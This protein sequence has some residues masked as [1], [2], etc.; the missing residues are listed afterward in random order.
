MGLG[1]AVV[2]NNILNNKGKI[3]W[4]FRE[5][6]TN[7]LDNGWRFL[8]E[9]DTD[10]FLS[11]SSNMSVCDWG[12]IIDIEPAILSIYAL[13]VGTELMLIYEGCRKYF[14]DSNTGQTL[15]L[16]GLPY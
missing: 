14:V 13:P 12:T 7:E 16:D 15:T 10:E 11:D 3:K 9:I 4:I 5:E 1:G 2:S 6:G 8:S